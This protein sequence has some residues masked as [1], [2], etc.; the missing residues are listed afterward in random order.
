MATDAQSLLNQAIVYAGYASNN[1]SLSLM[2]VSLLSQIS[3]TLN[4]TMS[5]DPQTLLAQAKCYTCFGSD[6]YSLRL[7]ELALLN[8]IATSLSS[9]GVSCGLTPPTTPPSTTCGVY[10]LQ[11]GAQ[12]GIWVWDGT[13]WQQLI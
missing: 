6:D 11:N 8:Q 2:V 4:A 5:T 9:G 13:K 7:M 1:Y 12:S 10:V 3:K